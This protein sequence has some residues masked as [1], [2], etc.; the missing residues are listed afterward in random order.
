MNVSTKVQIG[1]AIGITI[2][3][4]ISVIVGITMHREPG[5]MRVCWTALNVAE[6]STC[7]ETGEEISLSPLSLPFLVNSDGE[8]DAINEAI[9]I[10][11][12]QIGC[13]LLQY[14][15]ENQVHISISVNGAIGDGNQMGGATTH[16]REP[17]GRIR[18]RIELYSPGNLI[19][20]VLVH[21]LGHALGLAHDDYEYSI[22]YPTQRL[23]NRLQPI[24]FSSYD[25]R[26]LNE[27]Y[28]R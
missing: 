18:A 8:E 21:E 20:R 16:Y 26:I 1:I 9:E 15:D 6:Y 24:N 25:R 17:D 5:F 19:L 4:L 11:N 10:V 12:Q 27:L 7:S 28:C 23:S 14:S 13:E 22:M 3:A 2:L